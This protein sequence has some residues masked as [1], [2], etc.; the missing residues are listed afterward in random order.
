MLAAIGTRRALL[1]LCILL[2][3]QLGRWVAKPAVS[4]NHAAVKG[5]L[6]HAC[7]THTPFLHKAIMH[8][9]EWLQQS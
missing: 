5:M 4:I 7:A 3:R 2:L 1:L 8:H 9:P 6:A